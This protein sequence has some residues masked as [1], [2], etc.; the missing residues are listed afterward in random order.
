MH[1]HL[2]FDILAYIIAIILS[3]SFFKTSKKLY[4]SSLKFNYY[5][6]LI[7]GFILGAISLGSLNSYLSFGG[8]ILSKSVIGA[9][10]GGLLAVELFK[11]RYKIVGSTGA[12]F[13]PSLAIG[14]AIG[15][16]GCFMGGLDDFT[17]GV[18]TNLFLGYDF[19]D[20]IKRHP[21]QLYESFFMFMFFLYSWILFIK[22]RQYF[23]NK[24]FYI[25]I[26]YYASQR[27]MLEFLKPYKEILFGLNIFQFIAILML[28]YGIYYLKIIKKKS[29]I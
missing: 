19:G 23:E 13:V 22:D 9:L 18:E 8:F 27:F 5:S 21:V 15:R 7:V 25:F 28:L 24:I 11:Y 10:F 16:I 2:I 12:Y 20:G 4:P 1:E 6:Y 3:L 29:S 26:I 14:I 17:Y